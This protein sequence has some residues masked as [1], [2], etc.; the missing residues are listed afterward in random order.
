VGWE[1]T[2]C[3]KM[4]RNL[5]DKKDITKKTHIHTHCCSSASGFLEHIWDRQ[6]NGFLSGNNKKRWDVLD[7]NEDMAC[8]MIVSAVWLEHHTFGC[9]GRKLI[10]FR[11][12][13]LFLFTSCSY[14]RVES[15][16]LVWCVQC[17]QTL[18][19]FWKIFQT[20]L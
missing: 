20:L 13:F 1:C 10:S 4:G 6:Q 7:E 2:T 18:H 12:E 16:N 19:V 15:Y 11:K 14:I 9:S 8:H 5:G 17:S 3:V